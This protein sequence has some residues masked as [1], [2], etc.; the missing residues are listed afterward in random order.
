M[1]LMMPQQTPLIILAVAW[2]KTRA[3]HP[4]QHVKDCLS[5]I[6]LGSVSQEKQVPP[7]I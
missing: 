4:C 3:V 1:T 5:A 2:R 6:L 7:K